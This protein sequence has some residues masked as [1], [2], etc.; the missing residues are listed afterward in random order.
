MPSWLLSRV[1]F[2]F[3][4]SGEFAIIG[5]AQLVQGRFCVGNRQGQTQ[6]KIVSCDQQIKA[7]ADDVTEWVRTENLSEDLTRVFGIPAEKESK[8]NVHVNAGKIDYI[9]DLSFWFRPKE[10]EALYAA[11]P[12]W[13]GIEKEVYGELL[14]L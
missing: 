12:I 14:T 4:R 9:R 5:R 10:L 8:T 13:A 2:E 1:H 6:R 11:N 7:F 3:Q